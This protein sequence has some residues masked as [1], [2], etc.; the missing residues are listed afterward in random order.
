MNIAEHPPFLGSRRYSAPIAVSPHKL[1]F[2]ENSKNEN[3]FEE[4]LNAMSNVEKSILSLSE[5]S[6]TPVNIRQ[7]THVPSGT[8]L[9]NHVTPTP[10]NSYEYPD[11]H[12]NIENRKQRTLSLGMVIEPVQKVKKVLSP[13]LVSQGNDVVSLKCFLVALA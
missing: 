1:L 3:P 7:H 10:K 2:S 11:L 5:F 6:E 4:D 12:G 8:Y 13:R 9:R